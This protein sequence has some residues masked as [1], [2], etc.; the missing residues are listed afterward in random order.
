MFLVVLY[1]MFSSARYQTK[2][3]SG[4][5]TGVA[6]RSEKQQDLDISA[7]WGLRSSRLVSAF[8][9]QCRSCKLQQ[10]WIR[11][12]HPPTQ[13]N[14]RGLQIKQCWIKYHKNLFEKQQGFLLWLFFWNRDSVKSDNIHIA[15]S[16]CWVD[17]RNTWVTWACR[18]GCLPRPGTT[19]RHAFLLFVFIPRVLF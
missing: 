6:N 11:S 18:R 8:D 14:L 13:W 12:K 1:G 3:M 10:S 5:I 17:R 15:G 9:S 4:S 19:I 7:E 2:F 16:G